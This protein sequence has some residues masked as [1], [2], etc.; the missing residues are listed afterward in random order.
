MYAASNISLG[1]TSLIWNGFSSSFN[2]KKYTACIVRMYCTY[3]E[4]NV[5]RYKQFTMIVKHWINCA[6]DGLRC[7]VVLQI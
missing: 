1:I 3:Q 4:N 2:A 5:K 6:M 7:Q